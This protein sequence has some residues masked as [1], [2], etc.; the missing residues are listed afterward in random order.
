MRT[1]WWIS[2]V[3]ALALILAGCD[4]DKS[5]GAG[6]P[7][8]GGG[9]H[10]GSS[11]PTEADAEVPPIDEDGGAG[12]VVRGV[13]CAVADVRFP[14]SCVPVARE[15]LIVGLESTTGSPIDTATTLAGGTFSMPRPTQDTVWLTISD[16]VHTYHF[17]AQV[18]EVVVQGTRPV[19]V[20]V[21][22]DDYYN[23]MLAASMA[24]HADGHGVVFLH[25]VH[26]ETP[27]AG[28]VIGPFRGAPAYYEHG[29]P[30]AFT[31]QTPTTTTGFAAWF[32]VPKSL[33]EKYNVTIGGAPP[34]AHLGSAYPDAVTFLSDVQ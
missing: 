5:W 9:S 14:D 18:L 22:K 32:D 15:G 26:G 23:A 3:T 25:L 11:G 12:N 17:G 1:G 19:R 31:L 33:K 30:A 4:G 21:I 6:V 20:P 7:P 16:P 2:G 34:T 8:V 24:V 13:V 28:A 10:G 29:D 27:L